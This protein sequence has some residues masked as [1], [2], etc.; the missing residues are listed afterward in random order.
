MFAV[1]HDIAGYIRVV[2]VEDR[3]EVDKCSLSPI[4]RDQK[5][6]GKSSDMR[7][8]RESGHLMYILLG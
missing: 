1:G 2:V 4:G 3:T 6:D 5:I 7:L 8:L